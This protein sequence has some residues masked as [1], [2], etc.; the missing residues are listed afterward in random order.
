MV[1]TNGQAESTNS[2][3]L[4]ILFIFKH[5]VLTTIDSD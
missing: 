3:K 4:I 5:F 2:Q 1:K